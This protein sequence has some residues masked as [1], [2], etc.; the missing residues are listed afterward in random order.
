[1]T[2]WP[3]SVPVRVEFW[4]LASSA[5]AKSVLAMPTPST[6]LSSLIGVL[7]FGDFL[8]AGPVKGRGGEDE[9][10]RH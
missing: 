5:T 2:I 6:G 10:G 8:V 9:D 4:P 3:A 7:N 1:M